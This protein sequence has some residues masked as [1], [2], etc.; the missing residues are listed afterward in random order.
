MRQTSFTLIEPW[1]FIFH[2]DADLIINGQDVHHEM[3]DAVAQWDNQHF[4]EFGHSIGLALSKITI[5]AKMA[6]GIQGALPSP[7]MN[8]VGSTRFQ[9]DLERNGV[10]STRFLNDLDW[11]GVGSTRFQ[12]GVGSTRFQNGVGSTRFQNGVGST[13]FQNGVGSTRF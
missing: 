7:I 9:N 13:R 2:R 5:G 6:N 1:Y 10:G 3:T 8:G 12:N 11:N 4:Y